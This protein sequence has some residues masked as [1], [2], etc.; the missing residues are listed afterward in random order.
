VVVRHQMRRLFVDLPE[1]IGQSLV[2]WTTDIRLEDLLKLS[3]DGFGDRRADC[4]AFL[5]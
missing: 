4:G 1:T 5:S 3:A 2:K